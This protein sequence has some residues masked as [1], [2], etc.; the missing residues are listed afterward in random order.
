[1]T[2]TVERRRREAMGRHAERAAALL[3]WLKGYRLLARRAR[4]PA[5]EIDLVM[6]RGDTLVLVEV[7]YR[8]TLDSGLAALHPAAR[9]RLR[10]AAAH[11]AGRWGRHC[12]GWRIDLVLVQPWRWP[13]HMV[14]AIRE[15]D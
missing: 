5:G 9:Q 10:G 11:A 12:T 3:L 4:T 1:M 8:P 15:D 2:Q 7:K 6:R 14:A 13:V